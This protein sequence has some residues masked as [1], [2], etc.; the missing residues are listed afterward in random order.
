MQ[1]C[2]NYAILPVI[3]YRTFFGLIPGE[4][5]TP[6]GHITLPITFGD[7]N[8]YRTEHLSFTVTDFNMA[9]HAILGWLTLAK[10][11]AVPHY[12]YLKMKMLSP[13]GVITV[14]GNVRTAETGER[15]TLDEATALQLSSRMEQVLAASKE[16]DLDELVIVTKNPSKDAIKAKPKETKKVSLELEDP[17]KIVTIG[18]KLD[19]K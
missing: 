8:N 19:P 16:V 17:T 18:S 14:T 13:N 6:L 9:Y 11:M 10:F 1:K 5:A 4:P 2:D 12:A 7:R 15:E 3:N